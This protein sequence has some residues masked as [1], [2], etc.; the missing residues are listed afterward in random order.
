MM[1]DIDETSPS[2]DEAAAQA[3]LH[4]SSFQGSGFFLLNL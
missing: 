2:E 4:S 3:A 1:I